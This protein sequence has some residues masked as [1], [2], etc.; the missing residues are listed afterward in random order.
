MLS[1]LGA[2]VQ[3]LV[4]ELKFHTCGIAT[5]TQKKLWDIAKAVHRG[6]FIAMKHILLKKDLL[7]LLLLLLSCFSRV[8]LCAAP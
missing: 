6:K 2:Q 7:L 3:S 8:Q 4:R 5:H 1:L